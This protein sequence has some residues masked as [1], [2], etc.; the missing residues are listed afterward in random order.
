MDRLVQWIQTIYGTL[1]RMAQMLG[2]AQNVTPRAFML[3]ILVWGE[4]LSNFSSGSSGLRVKISGDLEGNCQSWNVQLPLPSHPFSRISHLG[5][6]KGSRIDSIPQRIC[7][8]LYHTLL[9]HWASNH[10]KD[11]SPTNASCAKIL[12]KAKDL[13]PSWQHSCKPKHSPDI[14][15]TNPT[16]SFWW[17]RQ[18]LWIVFSITMKT[19]KINRR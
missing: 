13:P 8:C 16:S 6:L 1:A 15:E 4:G 7:S 9:A 12:I 18:L 3:M 11:I 2:P 10:N 17:V 19:V 14:S 5:Q